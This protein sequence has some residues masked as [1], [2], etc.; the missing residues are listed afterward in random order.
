MDQHINC[1]CGWTGP[2][3]ML[4]AG[5]CPKCMRPAAVPYGYPPLPSWKKPPAQGTTP[6]LISVTPPAGARWCESS[7]CA[8]RWG[9]LL[10]MFAL[11]GVCAFS[12][13]RMMHGNA[14]HRSFDVKAK[15]SGDN[16]GPVYHEERAYV[17]PKQERR[18]PIYGDAPRVKPVP[19]GTRAEGTKYEDATCEPVEGARK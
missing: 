6:A 19:Q 17:I 14:C 10:V 15:P 3:A 18:E 16:V 7:T 8:P 11:V 5:A 13:T 12:I 1:P 4:R 9:S 2:G